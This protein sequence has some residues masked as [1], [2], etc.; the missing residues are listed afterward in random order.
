MNAPATG[1][2]TRRIVLRRVPLRGRIGVYDWE[3]T[4]PQP[5]VL[6]LEFD[7][8]HTAACT[9]DELADT[10]D[11]AE[12]IDQLR[13]LALSRPHRLVEAM[14]HSMCELLRQRF[15]LER[16]NLGLFKLAP[17]PGA[18]VG[19]VVERHGPLPASAPTLA[20]PGAARPETL[21]SCA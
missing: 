13:A 9:S 8:P 1:H 11:Y 15:G 5:M 16:L 10:V 4:E 18:E 12:V 21:W 20:A 14:A 17:F 7:L 2:T 3:Q 6:D 19:I